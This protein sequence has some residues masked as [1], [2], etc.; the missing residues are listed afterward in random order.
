MLTAQ[1]RTS[2]ASATRQAQRLS[3]SRSIV[4]PASNKATSSPS[5]GAS[6]EMSTSTTSAAPSI[7][8]NFGKLAQAL[9]GA[10]SKYV[11]NSDGRVV[12]RNR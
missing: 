2:I 11:R 5:S 10:D 1:A 9:E 4:I 3:G 12:L 6:A 7:A 8:G